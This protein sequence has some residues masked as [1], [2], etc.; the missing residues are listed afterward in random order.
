[1]Q[2]ISLLGTKWYIIDVHVVHCTTDRM[3][4]RSTD[5]KFFLYAN[6]HVLSLFYA[7]VC[8]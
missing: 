7:K 8:Q 3:F 5:A 6:I 4:I 1:V 2:T